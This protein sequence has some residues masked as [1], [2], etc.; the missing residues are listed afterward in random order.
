MDQARSTLALVSL[1]GATLMGAVYGPHLGSPD[2]TVMVA[3]LF[4][5]LTSSIAGFAFSAICGGILF[6]LWDDHVRI[7]QI[8]I[9]CS[10]ANQAVMVWSLRRDISWR[11]LAVC[12][13]GGACGVPLG[14]WALLHA[15][16]RSFENAIGLLLLAYGAYLLL[17]KQR[18]LRLDHPVLKAAVGFAGGVLG[19]ATALPSLPVMIWCQLKGCDNDAQRALSQ[20][21]I[22]AMQVLALAI[23][24]LLEAVAHQ[25]AGRFDVAESGYAAVLA[26]EPEQPQALLFAGVLASRAGRQ[27][28]LRPARRCRKPRWPPRHGPPANSKPRSR[29]RR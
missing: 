4:A 19:A 16:Q 26:L 28:P 2:P 7:V 22:L 12:V 1:A 5:S 6:H 13:G 8:M 14:A 10:I 23:T 15:D 29:R 18:T 24:P 11:A 17:G 3:I 20:P 25:E 9:A 21:F 27:S